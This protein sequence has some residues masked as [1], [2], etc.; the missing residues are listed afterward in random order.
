MAIPDGWNA[1]VELL[2]VYVA[3]GATLP[4]EPAAKTVTEPGAPP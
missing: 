4:L 3:I 2:A 1:Y